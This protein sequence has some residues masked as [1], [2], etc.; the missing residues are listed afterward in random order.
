MRLRR[1]TIRA[2]D[3]SHQNSREDREPLTDLSINRI[4]LEPIHTPTAVVGGRHT[5]L[6]TPTP[7][8]LNISTCSLVTS[9]RCPRVRGMIS[10]NARIC[11]VERIKCACA[12]ASL[13]VGSGNVLPGPSKSAFGWFARS[14]G[15]IGGYVAAIR[16]KGHV[17][18]G[19][20]VR[21]YL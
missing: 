13:V 17:C 20:I 7:T 9:S 8:P 5:S 10:R 16:Q 19:A 1:V 15:R 21:D 6:A 4:V 12:C 3:D 11:F 14:E 2:E 18:E